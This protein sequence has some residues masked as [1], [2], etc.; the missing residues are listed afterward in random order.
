MVRQLFDFVLNNM[1]DEFYVVQLPTWLDMRTDAQKEAG[2]RLS[3]KAAISNPDFWEVIEKRR[4]PVMPRRDTLYD[5]LPA[6][7]L[8]QVRR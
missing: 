8:P 5:D 7:L 1:R 2:R 3:E 4:Q 6:F